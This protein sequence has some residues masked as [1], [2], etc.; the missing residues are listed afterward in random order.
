LRTS[1][2]RY[3]KTICVKMW[4]RKNKNRP[5]SGFFTK[6][7]YFQVMNF[8]PV[9]VSTLYVWESFTSGTVY[10]LHRIFPGHLVI[11]RGQSLKSLATGTLRTNLYQSLHLEKLR[12]K[13]IT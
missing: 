7:A 3:A 2:S 5:V 8:I 9:K 12:I 6:I 11:V 1:G 4:A 13:L 10:S